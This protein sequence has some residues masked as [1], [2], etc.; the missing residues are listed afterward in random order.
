MP[1]YT[2]TFT[3]DE[4]H[5]FK[6]IVDRLNQDD[7]QVIEPIHAVDESN[8]RYCDRTTVMEMDAESA[9]TLRMGMKHLKIRRERSE[10]ELKTEAERDAR[11]RVKV[12][13][14]TDPDPQP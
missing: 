9:L 7:Y 11:H 3:P 8:S 5:K 13:I 1:K 2:Y 4:E 6:S 10:E 14:K 12:V